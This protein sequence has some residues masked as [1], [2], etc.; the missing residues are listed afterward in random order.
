M[1]IWQFAIDCLFDGGVDFNMLNP[2]PAV[3]AALLNRLA[4][5]ATLN[6]QRAKRLPVEN[7][8]GRHGCQ[9]SAD[10]H[11]EDGEGLAW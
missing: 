9:R 5:P 4:L 8:N 2:D 11:A 7:E 3:A 1:M 6:H 10:L